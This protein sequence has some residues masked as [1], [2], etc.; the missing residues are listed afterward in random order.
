MSPE[1]GSL[2]LGPKP[3]EGY[4]YLWVKIDLSYFWTLP[5]VTVL[6]RLVPRGTGRHTHTFMISGL[7][8][9]PAGLVPG[10]VVI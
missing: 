10:S 7:T 9:I 5:Q 1:P 8:K 2:P 6:R 3:E 4:P